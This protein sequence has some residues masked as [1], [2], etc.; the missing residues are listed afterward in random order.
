MKKLKRISFNLTVEELTFLKEL[1]DLKG[2]S[3]S[4]MLRRLIDQYRDMYRLEQK[5]KN[6]YK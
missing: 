3:T 6:D 1:S 5:N 4:E 2:I